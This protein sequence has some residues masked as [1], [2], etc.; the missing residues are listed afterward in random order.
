VKSQA[1]DLIEP[2]PVDPHGEI[3]GAS[4]VDPAVERVSY[5]AVVLMRIST[6]P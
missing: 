1:D 3:L 4:T 2:D 5:A 6:L